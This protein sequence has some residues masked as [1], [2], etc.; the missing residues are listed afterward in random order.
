MN[1]G[2]RAG[3]WLSRLL[4]G[5]FDSARDFLDRGPGNRARQAPGRG[6]LEE[7]PSL[8]GV[9]P[10]VVLLTDGHRQLHLLALDPPRIQ[11]GLCRQHVVERRQAVAPARPEKTLT[12][13]A[14]P[15]VAPM[16]QNKIC[17]LNTVF[18]SS[19][20]ESLPLS[21][22]RMSAS[23]GP[24]SLWYFLLGGTERA[25]QQS[26][27]GRRSKRPSLVQRRSKRSM[28]SAFVFL[29]PLNG[30]V[31]HGQTEGREQLQAIEFILDVAREIDPVLA[32]R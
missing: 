23:P 13:L 26:S 27:C 3:S 29:E 20:G 10:V 12:F 24:P 28:T 17:A 5:C 14:W 31:V 30:G 15:S 22:S 9:D 16:S 8:D 19:S 25:W 21:R 2:N 32:I 6:R 1:A 4:Q 7:M 11:A 18:R